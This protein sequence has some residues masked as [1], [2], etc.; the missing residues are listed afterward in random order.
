MKAPTWRRRVP[1]AS[2]F[3][4][5][6]LLAQS[7]LAAKPGVAPAPG[8][9]GTLPGGLPVLPRLGETMQRDLRSGLAIGGYDPV[10]YQIDHRATPGQPDHELVQ[11]GIVWRFVSAANLAAFQ[12][13]PDIY[14][15]AF[16]GF[17]PT[18]VADDRAVETDPRL[19]AVTGSRLFLFRTPE[20]RSAFLADPALLHRAETQWR[21]VYA[22]IAR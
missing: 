19:F 16:A 12:D 13:A 10:A 17:D 3:I 6:A 7:A 20:N 4:A 9:F 8:P 15:P 18:G 21:A 11:A 2:A 5:L 22:M 14:A 1:R